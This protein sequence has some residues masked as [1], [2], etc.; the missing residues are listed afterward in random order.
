[1]INWWIFRPESVRRRDKYTPEA[2]SGETRRRSLDRDEGYTRER[3]ESESVDVKRRKYEEEGMVD[4]SAQGI[5]T[6]SH[7]IRVSKSNVSASYDNLP[8]LNT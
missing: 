8:V 2:M 7:M 1:M 6:F 4:S 5:I 3:R